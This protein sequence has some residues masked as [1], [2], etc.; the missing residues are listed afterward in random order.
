MRMRKFIILSRVFV[1][2]LLL[3]GSSEA[4]LF[5]QSRTEGFVIDGHT[6]KAHFVFNPYEAGVGMSYQYYFT[7]RLGLQLNLDGLIPPSENST[8]DEAT[9]GLGLRFIPEFRYYPN[10]RGS[11]RGNSFFIGGGPVFKRFQLHERK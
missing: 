8:V 4:I 2:F 1:T 9:K 6:L 11:N 7:R 5:A 3:L 10:R